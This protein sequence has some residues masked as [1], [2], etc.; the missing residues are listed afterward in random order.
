LFYC[1]RTGLNLQQRL[2]YMSRAIICS[3]TCSRRGDLLE[4]LEDK[5]EVAQIQKNI[6][7]C[8]NAKIANLSLM[9]AS[10]EDTS[11][12]L[13]ALQDVVPKLNSQLLTITQVYCLLL[14]MF[15]AIIELDS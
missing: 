6:L 15:F 3:K 7:E 4:T 2:E 9:S 11:G 14:P 13:K 12:E 10:E 1:F 5:A 8:I